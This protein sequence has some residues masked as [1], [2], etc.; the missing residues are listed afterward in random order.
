LPVLGIG[1][2]AVAIA[3][4]IVFGLDKSEKKPKREDEPVEEHIEAEPA[5]PKMPRSE[6]PADIHFI[7]QNMSQA[8]KMKLIEEWVK[9][10]ITLLLSDGDLQL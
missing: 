4:Y 10:Q 3:G 5:V 9:N 8:E 1:L 6:G 2:A 7:P